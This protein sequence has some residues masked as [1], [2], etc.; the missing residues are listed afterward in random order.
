MFFFR[1]GISVAQDNNLVQLSGVVF[2]LDDSRVKLLPFAEISIQNSFRTVF[3]NEKGFYSI[4]AARGDTVNFNYLS[5]KETQFIIPVDYQL[6]HITLNQE[7]IRDTIF[8]PKAVIHPWPDKNHFRPEFLAMDVEESMQQIAEANLA[9]NR[10]RDLLTLTPHDGQE[11]V[12]LYLSQQAQK[13]YYAGQIPPQ[14]IF[15]PAAW[16]E[17]FNAWKRGDFKKKRSSK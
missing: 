4:A 6:D 3:G 11:N 17:F 13:Y 12:S 1:W 7:L 16:I 9:K 2:T 10:L 15:S 14:K 5:F 8:L